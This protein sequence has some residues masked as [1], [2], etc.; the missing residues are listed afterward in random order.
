MPRLL[1][2]LIR[3]TSQQVHLQKLYPLSVHAIRPSKASLRRPSLPA[4]FFHPAHHKQSLLL[5]STPSNPI[6]ASRDYIQHKS[7][8]P[9]AYIPERAKARA[10]G[11][12]RP[13]QMNA[14]ERRWWANPYLRMLSSPIRKCIVTNR[15]LPSDFLVRLGPVQ[16]PTTCFTDNKPAAVLIPDGLQH[17]KF[18]ARRVGPAAYVLCSQEAVASIKERGRVQVRGQ[19]P[20][21]RIAQHIVHLLRLRVLQELEL[22]VEQ[23]EH[24][25]GSSTGEPSQIL[26]RL[27]RNEWTDMKTNG[28]IPFGNAVAVLVVPPL[29]KDPTSKQKPQPSMSVAPLEQDVKA[30]KPLPP[31]SLLYSCQETPTNST[32]ASLPDILPPYQVPL[33]NGLAL[34]PNRQQRVAC[35]RLLLRILA[36]EKKRRDRE[37]V[38]PKVPEAKDKDKNSVRARGGEKGSHAFLLA[39]SSDTTLQADVA[40]TAIALWRVRMFEGGTVEDD[41]SWTSPP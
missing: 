22:L 37:H 33:Y 36:I 17:T 35:H 27:T 28:H 15:Y 39:S 30:T 2:R 3:K 1:P 16:L 18:T 41:H 4:P 23:L 40:A 25:K 34:F 38:C 13:R 10:N 21:P 19:L 6:T 12:D 26:R 20:H 5:S 31:I 8:P 32:T 29:N 7:L 9:R 14:N 11:Y 24:W